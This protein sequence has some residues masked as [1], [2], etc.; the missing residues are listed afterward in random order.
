MKRERMVSAAS[1]MFMA[2]MAVT[3]AGLAQQRVPAV[4]PPQHGGDLARRVPGTAPSLSNRPVQHVANPATPEGPIPL[5]SV[6]QESLAIY[7]NAEV[8]AV[9]II[10]SYKG[11]KQRYSFHTDDGA[12]AIV[13]GEYP[14]GGGGARWTLTARVVRE[15]GA[16]ALVEVTKSPVVPPVTDGSPGK[17]TNLLEGTLPY[18]I[19]GVVLIIVA[20][21]TLIVMTSRAKAAE[22]QAVFAREREMEDERIHRAQQLD[23]AKAKGTGSNGPGG[24]VGVGG[25]PPAGPPTMQSWG[26]AEVTAGS[27]TGKRFP[28]ATGPNII[29]RDSASGATVVLGDPAVSSKHA[30]IVMTKDRRV[31]FTDDSSNGSTVD[32]AFVQY[33]AREIH[34]GSVITMG[35]TTIRVTIAVQPGAAVSAPPVQPSGGRRAETVAVPALNVRPRA[36]A[37]SMS[38]GAELEVTGGPNAGQRFPIS[39]P[40]TTIGREDRDVLLTD[41]AVS[42]NHALLTVRDGAFF[43]SDDGSSH[44]TRVNNEPMAMAGRELRDGDRISLGAGPTTLV[45]HRI[46]G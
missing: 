34:T 8:R 37:T 17:S 36:A 6:S 1:M 33:D 10:G 7:Q 28:L 21:V 3:V 19:G 27:S 26:F 39:Q 38:Y 16:Y 43:L 31:L 2:Y 12:D 11:I 20:I 13:V 22:R 46:G 45:F 32:G 4:P 9:G 5:A 14:R 44:G 25:S 42:R 24:T 29:G 35:A 41:P 40:L 23:I 15:E 18:L 30:T